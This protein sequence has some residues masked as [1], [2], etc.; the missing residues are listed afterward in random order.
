VL[1][2]GEGDGPAATSMLEVDGEDGRP[3]GGV[4]EIQLPLPGIYRK[5]TC[6]ATSA[7][8]SGRAS[9]VSRTP[10]RVN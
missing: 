1:A 3:S 5:D 2:I 10:K 6:G 8:L 7:L 9:K 4:M